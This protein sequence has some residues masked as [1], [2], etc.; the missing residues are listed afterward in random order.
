[1]KNIANAETTPKKET[2]RLTVEL[3]ADLSEAVKNLSQHYG[4]S[5]ADSLRKAITVSEFFLQQR[6]EGW[7]IYL[8][9]GEEFQKVVF[10]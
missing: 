5:Q 1:M 9:K 8:K 3:S 6:K 4:C 10:L 7:T 2:K